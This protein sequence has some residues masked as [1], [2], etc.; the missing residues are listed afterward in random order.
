MKCRC[1]LEL[2]ASHAGGDEWLERKGKR[3][4][5]GPEQRRGRKDLFETFQQSS[6][7]WKD[8]RALDDRF[9]EAKGKQR[10][11]PAHPESGMARILQNTAIAVKPAPTHAKRYWITALVPADGSMT[12]RREA[13]DLACAC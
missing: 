8:G 3:D 5:P 10:V 11:T 1:A 12:T 9:L 4:V 13:A 2:D 6:N 7:P